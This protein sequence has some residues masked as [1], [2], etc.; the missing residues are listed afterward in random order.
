MAEAVPKELRDT[1]VART[2][3]KSGADLQGS[4]ST[5]RQP[6]RITGSASNA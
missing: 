4:E 6:I 5:M 3:A 1:V 2:A